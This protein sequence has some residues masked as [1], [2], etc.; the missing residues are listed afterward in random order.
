MESQYQSIAISEDCA[1]VAT[2]GDCG[3]HINVY[4]AS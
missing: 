4:D 3:T 2:I 1:L